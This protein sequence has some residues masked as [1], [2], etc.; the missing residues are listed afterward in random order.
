MYRVA[1][2]NFEGS[3]PE[4]KGTNGRA[5]DGWVKTLYQIFDSYDQLCE[6]SRQLI[7]VFLKELYFESQWFRCHKGN[8]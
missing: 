8:Q 6:L 2:L 4:K 7:G 5:L 3:S 1:L